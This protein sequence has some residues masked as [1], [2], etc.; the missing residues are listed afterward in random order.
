MA[1]P[2]WKLEFD[3]PDTYT[4]E[5]GLYR[6]FEP[7]FLCG[8][9]GLE[10]NMYKDPNTGFL[11]M[12]PTTLTEELFDQDTWVKYNDLDL[13]EGWWEQVNRN[14][15]KSEETRNKQ[16]FI[17]NVG[18]VGILDSPE[19]TPRAG[20]FTL[21][22]LLVVIGIIAITV[23]LSDKDRL[24]PVAETKIGHNLVRD[25]GFELHLH[26]ESDPAKRYT[27]LLMI[28]FDHHAF[29]LSSDGTLTCCYYYGDPSVTE[30]TIIEKI[31]VGKLGKMIGKDLRISFIPIPGMG[32]SITSTEVSV[33]AKVNKG[34]AI[35]E[36]ITGGGFVRYPQKTDES[37]YKYN[38]DPSSIVLYTLPID[39]MLGIGP[40]E[41]DDITG[42][43][44]RY[45]LGIARIRYGFSA[46]LVSPIF[47]VGYFPSVES[48]TLEYLQVI[49]NPATLSGFTVT[50]GFTDEAGTAS[51]TTKMP[52]LRK[53]GRTVIGMS[54]SGGR[55]VYTPMITA[56][57]FNYP[58]VTYTRETTAVETKWENIEFTIDDLGNFVEGS[59]RTVSFD[60][61]TFKIALRG[62]TTWR[63]YHCEDTEADPPVWK[64]ISGGIATANE[65]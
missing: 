53:R 65:G 25:E 27:N 55:S 4:T 49:Q 20:G 56:T 21:I 12:K 19:I 13:A 31:S 24:I 38:N 41:D 1:S 46:K 61:Q 64:I 63:L 34:T 9:D 14:A 44:T 29:H 2:S 48:S 3:N 60:E 23:G 10:S 39:T 47:D 33:T 36:T 30:P 6:R 5:P 62:D 50:T 26:I 43:H 18:E 40:N 37:G 59:C 52:V 7:S 58:N 8:K 51:V 54:Y 16:E 45:Q 11:M 22:N 57:Q 32:Y 42:D 15:K 17:A 28:A 35:N